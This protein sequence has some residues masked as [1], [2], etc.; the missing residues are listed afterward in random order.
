M[1]D[2]LENLTQSVDHRQPGSFPAGGTPDPIL[3]ELTRRPMVAVRCPPG[4]YPS[5]VL[6]SMLD[7]LLRHGKRVLV[8]AQRPEALWGIR[9]LLPDSVRPLCREAS[10]RPVRGRS[11]AA[12]RQVR[13]VLSG[14][15]AYQV[16]GARMRP[17]ELGAWLR[18]RAA[19]QAHVPDPVSGPAPLTIE[20]FG[21]LLRLAARLSP[22][23]R[24]AAM[25]PLPELSDLPD[26][27]TAAAERAALMAAT[28]RM[29]LLAAQGVDF[30][31]VRVEDRTG[32]SSVR[33][34]LQNV[35][36]LIEAGD[37]TWTQRLSRQLENP[38]R[39]ARWSEHL[40]AVRAVLAE[41]AALEP[42]F[43]GHHVVVPE[44]AG[45][46]PDAMLARLAE[47][48][49]RFTTDRGLNRMLQPVLH[50]IADESLID[51]EPLR[52]PEDIDLAVVGVRRESI[53]RRLRDLWT[54]WIDRL[55]IPTPEQGW[56][57]AEVWSADLL[58]EAER[59]HDFLGY[60]W[61]LL[62]ERLAAL[63]PGLPVE[64]EAPVLRR[65]GELLEAA[66]EVFEGNR[67][68]ARQRAVADRIAPW[69]G[70]TVAW[71]ALSG[72][73]DA[74]AEMRRL[75]LLQPE[76]M[77]YNALWDR[78]AA[79]A[80]EWS[81]RIAAGGHPVLSGQECLDAWQWRRA[82]TWLAERGLDDVWR[83]EADG[84]PQAWIMPVDRA[85]TEF[86]GAGRFDV[87]IVAEATGAPMTA[88]PVLSLADR[89]VA[90]GDH[91]PASGVSLYDVVE[92]SGPGP[93]V[94]E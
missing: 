1:S 31:S 45:I 69:P 3:A 29:S 93:I 37:G 63:L 9:D 38:H 6:R 11:R 14:S 44:S 68:M 94:L 54:A 46:D 66:A 20:E 8:V 73:D 28:E 43:R 89:V 83:D 62:A 53:R 92:Q 86:S 81:A 32:L 76:V 52:T 51:G 17:A 13:Y 79:V 84:G 15:D 72:W 50:R 42:E 48:R 64:P 22:A 80:P 40:T 41:A 70:L 36:A 60:R 47:I 16:G 67:V 75:V 71:Q 87:V 21:A 4:A 58:A 30:A 82:R 88:L 26:A 33:A 85:I 78:L 74:I 19:E 55:W 39:R 25:R 27:A 7:S 12:I 91:T 61:P 23:D 18:E 5:G 57:D 77:R 56:S 90:L 2:L 35:I 59:T 10:P 34:D 49:E 24:E 65:A